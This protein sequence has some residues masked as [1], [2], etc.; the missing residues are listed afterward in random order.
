MKLGNSVLAFSF[1][2]MDSVIEI[3]GNYS[4]NRRGE[5][6]TKELL[7]LRSSEANTATKHGQVIWIYLMLILEMSGNKSCLCKAKCK[8]CWG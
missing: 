3:C 5:G 1:L 2:Q 7:I 4:V 6:K 8:P